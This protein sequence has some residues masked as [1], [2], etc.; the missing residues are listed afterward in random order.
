MMIVRC[1]ELVLRRW[2]ERIA[3]DEYDHIERGDEEQKNAPER[4]LR[5]LTAQRV[6]Q[7][8]DRSAETDR[9]TVLSTS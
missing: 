9:L 5:T 2:G 4:S 3:H 7:S 8:D 1:N 6:S